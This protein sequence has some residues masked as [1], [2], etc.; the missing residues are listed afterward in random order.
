MGLKYPGVRDLSDDA[1]QRPPGL[2]Y[3]LS[4]RRFDYPARAQMGSS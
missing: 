4:A 3:F 2:I 1:P